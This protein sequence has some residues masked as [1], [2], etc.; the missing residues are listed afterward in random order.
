MHSYIL[1][2]CNNNIDDYNII[3]EDINYE[4]DMI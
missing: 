2:I 3:I 1:E 4:Y